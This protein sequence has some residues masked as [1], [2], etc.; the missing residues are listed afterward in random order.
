M[1]IIK[2]SY[3][4]ELHP[5]KEQKTLLDKHFGCNRFVFNYFLNQRKDEYLNNKKTLTYNTQAKS[6]T[7]LKK[8]EEY[9]WLKEINSQSL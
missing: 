5:N 1:K 9:E 4:F 8:L 3:K 2:K 6:L 7:K